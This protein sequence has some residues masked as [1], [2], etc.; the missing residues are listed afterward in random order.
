MSLGI[1]AVIIFVL[2]LID[3][4][5]RWRQAAKGGS[6]LLI[7]AILGVLGTI[8][9]D[10]YDRWRAAKARRA[11]AIQSCMDRNGKDQTT[12]RACEVD[13]DV[14]VKQNY[15]TCGLDEKG[16]LVPAADDNNGG[17]V[18][19]PPAGYTIDTSQGDIFDRVACEQ[20]LMT[21]LPFKLPAGAILVSVSKACAINPKGVWSYNS[22]N[23]VWIDI[24]AGLVQKASEH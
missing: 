13:P 21:Q 12:R 14:E 6:A 2:Y 15:V 3:K 18:P 7:L 16:H 22:K 20:K 1:A 4:H 10:K 8:G 23:D 17:C 19:P 11:T 9:Y 24:S 5:G